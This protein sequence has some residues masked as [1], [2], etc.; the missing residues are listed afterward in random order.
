MIVIV[1]Y[2]LIDKNFMLCEYNANIYMLKKF[3]LFLIYC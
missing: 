3:S 1:E 2:I